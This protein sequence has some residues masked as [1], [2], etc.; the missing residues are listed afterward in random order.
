[1]NRSDR[2]YGQLFDLLRESTPAESLTPREIQAIISEPLPDARTAAAWTSRLGLASGVI[3]VAVIATWV[4]WPESRPADGTTARLRPSASAPVASAPTTT[5]PNTALPSAAVRENAAQTA[6]LPV[7]P[8][9]A[10]TQHREART[11]ANALAARVPSLHAEGSRMSRHG[12]GASH[13]RTLQAPPST[14]AEDSTA[15]ANG[16]A[17]LQPSR[18]AAPLLLAHRTSN[19]NNEAHVTRQMGSVTMHML[20]LRP[21]ELKALG[22]TFVDG[23]IETFGEEYYTLA[24]PQDRARFAQMGMDTT[25]SSGIVR[26]HL[27]I[28]TFGLTTYKHR[29]ERVSNYSRIAPIIA[30]N[31]YVHDAHMSTSMLNSFNRSPIM[32]SARRSIGPMVNALSRAIATDDMGSG[33]YG[34]DHAN[35]ARILVPVHMRLGDAPIIGSTKRRGADIV[36]WFYPTAEFVAALPARYRTGLQEEL[37]AIADVVECNLP[38]RE[39]CWRMTGEPSLLDYCKQSSGALRSLNVSPNPANGSVTVRYYLEHPRTVGASLYSIR[40]ELVR[41]L[42]A[43]APMVAGEHSMSVALGNIQAGAYMVVMRSV[44]GEQV[45]ERLIVL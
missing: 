45:S 32:D 13:A 11:D 10:V 41:D 14:A 26:K 16:A 27:T 2:T 6:Q 34:L 3:A 15:S 44:E 23:Y 30:L 5:S 4:L 35:P 18:A 31:S 42:V 28:D 37:N 36:L 33:A 38:P 9:H 19:E 22:V 25:V 43:S 40:G 17:L 24:T 29:W 8:T 20:E 12:S 7:Q 39:V 1:M 21:D